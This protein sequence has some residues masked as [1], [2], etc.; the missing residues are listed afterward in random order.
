M[1]QSITDPEVIELLED[2]QAEIMRLSRMV[3]GM[4]TLASISEGTEKKKPISRSC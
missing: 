1:D 3:G 2:A 4:L